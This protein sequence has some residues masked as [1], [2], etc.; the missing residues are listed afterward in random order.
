MPFS[1]LVAGVL[2]TECPANG[3]MTDGQALFHSGMLTLPIWREIGEIASSSK[4]SASAR[5]T[6]WKPS[7]ATPGLK[8]PTGAGERV[9]FQFQG[10][11]HRVFHLLLLT[12]QQLTWNGQQKKLQY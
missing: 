9:K 7:A 10:I 12:G 6:A 11:Q 4:C 1:R 2:T 3:A 5:A 8:Q